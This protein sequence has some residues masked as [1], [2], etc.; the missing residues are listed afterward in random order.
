MVKATELEIPAP[1]LSPG[2]LTALDL[3]QGAPITPLV[4]LTTMESGPWEDFT[5]E[6]VTWWRSQYKKVTRCG[7]G[8]DMG[9]DVIAISDSGWENFQCKYYAK[10]LSVADSILEVGKIIYYSFLDEYTLPSK[11]YFVSPKGSSTDLI[12]V[13]SDVSGEK[14]KNQLIARWDKTCKDEITKKKSIPLNGSLLD[15]INN[16]VDFSIFDDIPPL[17]LIELHSHTPYH[18]IRFG[19]YHKIRPEPPKAPEDI[20][21]VCEQVYIQALLDAFSEYKA[22][23]IDMVTLP[24]STALLKEMS[25]A[26]NNYYSAEALDRFSRDWLPQ[27][28]FS[29]LKEQCHEAISASINMNHQN[30][31]VRYLNTSDTA[32]K[33]TYDSHP[34]NHYMKLQDKKG[35]CHH[36]ANEGA[37]KWINHETD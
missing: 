27:N 36:L 23:K 37:I 20:D 22:T 9:R 5:L 7:G 25:S 14:M 8:G 24:K 33:V 28:C 34:L 4:R 16:K 6:L 30:G 1:K 32:V 12:K 26:R 35:L 19:T 15:Y 10:K 2:M 11:Y 13:L 21:W 3:A 17:K 31:Y 18:A 29:D